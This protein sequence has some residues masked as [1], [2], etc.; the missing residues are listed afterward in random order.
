MEG[1]PNGP[2]G[3]YATQSCLEIRV[4][5]KL[6][7][8]DKSVMECKSCGRIKLEVERTPWLRNQIGILR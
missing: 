8:S 4:K 5:Q 1:W 2:T 3:Y 6:I 7:R